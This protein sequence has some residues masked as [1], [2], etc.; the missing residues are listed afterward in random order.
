MSAPEVHYHGWVPCIDWSGYRDDGILLLTS[1]REGLPSVVLE[2]AS[3]GLLC[4]CSDVGA[5]A[6]LHLP[7]ICVLPREEYPD[8]LHTTIDELARQVKSHLTLSVLSLPSRDYRTDL[9]T[10]LQQA[11]IIQ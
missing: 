3:H 4:L 8:F 5:L 9:T 10:Y 7:N 11:G 1:F 2:A 6:S